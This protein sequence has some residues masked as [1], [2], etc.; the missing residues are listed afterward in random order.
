MNR[1]LLFL[2][3]VLVAA[4]MLFSGL[5]QAQGGDDPLTDYCTQRSDACLSNC[6]QYNVSLWGLSVPTPRTF[7][8]VGECSIAYVGCLM[9]R[10]RLGV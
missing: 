2:S 3:L 8:C 5:A 4:S 6:A 1:T 10:Y 7:A 9:M